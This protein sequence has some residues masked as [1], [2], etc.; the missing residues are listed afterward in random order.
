MR[1]KEDRTRMRTYEEENDSW[2][3]NKGKKGTG[4]KQERCFFSP[5]IVRLCTCNFQ[6][7]FSRCREI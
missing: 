7:H 4:K 1:R 2:Q 6:R 5:M 3:G